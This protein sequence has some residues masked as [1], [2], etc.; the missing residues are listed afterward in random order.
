M[1]GIAAL[2]RA[3]LDFTSRVAS[4]DDQHWAT[5]TVCDEW[6]VGGLVGH[7]VGGNHMAVALIGGASAAD[8][9]GI[10]RAMP[11]G[12]VLGALGTSLA[13]QA[14]AFAQPGALELTVH[15]PASDMSGAQLLGFRTLDLA[16]H[17]WDLSRSVG[18]DEQLDPELVE[19]VWEFIQPLAPVVGQIG[20]FGTGPSGTVAESADLQTRLIDLLGRRP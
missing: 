2:D 15:H 17:T 20:V 4:L 11:E 9:V 1:D 3:G 19:H 13:E 10:L 18:L 16:L 12:D 8:V 7:I 14:A 6:D 5:A